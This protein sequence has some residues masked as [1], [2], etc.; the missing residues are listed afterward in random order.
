MIKLLPLYNKT[1]NF[2]NYCSLIYILDRKNTGT[3]VLK[4]FINNKKISF[5]IRR[6]F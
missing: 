6:T 4:G 3:T 2:L 1:S 5:Y